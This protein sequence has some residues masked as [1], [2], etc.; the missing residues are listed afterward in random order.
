MSDIAKLTVALYANSAQFSSELRKSQQKAGQWKKKV[1]GAFKAASVAAATSA[2][3][4]TTALT[5]I[6]VRQ[7]SLIDQTAKFADRIGV[8]TEALSQLR[9]SAELTGLGASQLDMAMQRMTRRIAEAAQGSGEAAP[10]IKQLG[11]DAQ[12]LG[13]M[14][15]DQQL[16]TLADAFQNVGSQSERVRLAFKL[17]DSGGV[18]MINMLATGSD[19]LKDMAAEADALGITLSRVDA[20]K[21]EMA[22]DAM[23][24]VSAT[25]TAF[26]QELTTQLAPIVAGI[27]EMFTENAKKHGGM[28][29]FI[30]E[31]L[32][33]IFGA[34]GKVGDAYKGWVMIFA[35]IETAWA[36]LK[37]SMI[38]GA[39]SVSPEAHS[40]TKSLVEIA[41]A[42][43]RAV[44]DAAAEHIDFFKSVQADIN[45][46]LAKK[47]PT[48]IDVES[49][50]AD[51]QAIKEE[52]L[53]LLNAPLPSENIDNWIQ[54]NREKFQKLAEDYTNSLNGEK[55]GG[56]GTGGLTGKAAEAARKQEEKHAK[57]QQMRLER[58]RNEMDSVR[59]SFLEKS[60]LEAE[61]WQ[62]R[63]ETLNVWRE[64]EIEALKGNKE[65][66]RLIEEKHTD[67]TLK[68]HKD[69]QKNLEGIEDA[70]NQVRLQSAEKV[71]D[72][73]SGLAKV[74]SGEQSGI[75]KA[76]FVAQKAYSL[77]SV[78][79]SSKEAIGKAWASAA[80]P[81]NL[82]AVGMA[83]AETGALSAAVS[84][85][86]MPTFH[87]GGIGGQAAD[88]NSTRLRNNEVYAKILKSEEVIT[89]TDPRHRNN[90]SSGGG[91]SART[92]TIVINNNGEPVTATGFMDDEGKVQIFLEKADKHIAEGIH[93]GFGETAMAIE[94]VLGGSRAGSS[95]R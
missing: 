10:A 79:L 18:A 12:K 30:T 53:K 78:L 72:S 49:A 13:Q 71:F 58:S 75:Y 29:L 89:D 15:P 32:D 46:Q 91:N 5:A 50:K 73:M 17:F 55:P 41:T 3:A 14:T 44:V 47:S 68:N 70:R 76:M 59:Q 77:A 23:T 52:Y 63:Q 16:H 82:P 88:S 8:S 81:F 67:L 43:M 37:A 40:N 69:H 85:V 6:Y 56:S 34:V 86:A 38:E 65:R 80:F 57:E 21:V 1:S 36:K 28:S 60:A 7:A 83:L 94:N 93:G 90:I 35:A 95:G 31:G 74:F 27:G 19:G 25:T 92:F 33:S 48:I 62:Q 87:T 45:A 61:Q 39:F 84:A 51:Y 20:A 24:R 66:I 22:N 64:A 54:T 42:P 4:L 26:S 9:Y 2:V 11:L